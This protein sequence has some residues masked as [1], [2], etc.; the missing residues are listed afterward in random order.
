MLDATP[1]TGRSE[2]FAAVAVALVAFGGL[3]WLW[4]GEWR[5]AVTGV[6]T[7]LT[8][9]IVGVAVSTTPPAM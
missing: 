6:V 3:A 2:L 9:A 5:W 4:S 8:V 7:A 1:I